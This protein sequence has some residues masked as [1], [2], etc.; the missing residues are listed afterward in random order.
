MIDKI[1]NHTK[2]NNQIKGDNT[3]RD[4]TGLRIT[5]YDITMTLPFGLSD[6]GLSSRYK[7]KATNLTLT[8]E[9]FTTYWSCVCGGV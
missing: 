7:I 2:P 5:C 3:L 9:M 4:Y 1:I 6:Y 8:K